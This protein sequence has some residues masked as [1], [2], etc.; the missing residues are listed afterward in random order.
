FV[1]ALIVGAVLSFLAVYAAGYVVVEEYGLWRAIHGAWRLFRSHWLPSLETAVLVLFLNV[2]LTVAVVVGAGIFFLPGLLVWV[3]AV[4]TGSPV[5][6]IAGIALGSVLFLFFLLAIGSFFTV[7]VTS[8]WT[9]L[10]MRMHR[11]GMGSRVLHW[12]GVV[13]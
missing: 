8:V 5:L 13:K 3:L 12:F 2:L 4:M 11:E 9:I 7:F 10:F 6:F 1:L